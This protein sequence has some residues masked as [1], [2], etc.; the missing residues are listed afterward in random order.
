[1]PLDGARFHP[2]TVC[3]MVGKDVAVPMEAQQVI[4]LFD[5]ADV[6]RSG[7]WPK[8]RVW[9]V[10]LWLEGLI[11]ELGTMGLWDVTT[12]TGSVAIVWLLFGFQATV[13]CFCFLHSRFWHWA[14]RL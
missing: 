12:F 1:M 4:S 5:K 2:A 10:G 11:K 6:D 13:T 8:W 7:T 9:G 3:Q 14:S